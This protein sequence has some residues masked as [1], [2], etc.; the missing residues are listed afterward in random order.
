VTPTLIVYA[1]SSLVDVI[2]EGPGSAD[3]S[4]PKLVVS[5]LP[6]LALLMLMRLLTGLLGLD[7]LHRFMGLRLGLKSMKK[8][9]NSL[10]GKAVSLRLEWFE[11]PRN[12]D[13]LQR[14]VE[15][16]DEQ[17]QAQ[18]LLHVQ[19]I[20]MTMFTAFGVLFALSAVHWGVPILMIAAT[21]VLI[22]FG[23]ATLATRGRPT[24]LQTDQKPSEGSQQ[25]L[26]PRSP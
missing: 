8:L 23:Q 17:A 3:D 11:I 9:E 22:A 10:F 16:M 15:V 24:S 25:A 2:T 13:G 4:V 12:Y 19:N 6:W 20:I 5:F 26:I 7:P 21:S 14:A 18:A 1:T